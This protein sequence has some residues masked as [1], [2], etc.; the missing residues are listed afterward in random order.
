MD[1]AHHFASDICDN[2]FDSARSKMHCLLSSN[3][4]SFQHI[5]QVRLKV[6]KDLEILD[7]QVV[8]S[9]RGEQFDGGVSLESPVKE[10]LLYCCKRKI[11]S[12]RIQVDF[13]FPLRTNYHHLSKIDSMRIARHYQFP[14]VVRFIR[15]FIRPGGDY[16]MRRAVVK[17]EFG[18]N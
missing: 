18:R 5:R 9:L 7:I 1:A 10:L 15:F 17:C 8:E 14:I 6:N 2:C 4:F 16:V 11:S 13:F 12:S 3:Y